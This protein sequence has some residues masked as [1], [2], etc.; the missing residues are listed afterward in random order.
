[1]ESTDLEPNEEKPKQS[2]IIAPAPMIALLICL[3]LLLG[4]RSGDGFSSLK[5]SVLP[6]DALGTSEYRGVSEEQNRNRYDVI[7]CNRSGEDELNVAIGYFDAVSADWL[8]KGWYVIPRGECVTLLEGGERPLY[9]YVAEGVG[10]LPGISSSQPAMLC[11]HESEP[12]S[13]RFASCN[14]LARRPE[15][16]VLPFT[17][18]PLSGEGG[19]FI[20]EIGG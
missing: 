10:V 1:M 16:L 11:A 13:L 14:E 5:A 3:V 2:T 19:E 15:Y 18:L 7:A 8:S 17:E 20:W 4:G 9:A 12:F 6:D